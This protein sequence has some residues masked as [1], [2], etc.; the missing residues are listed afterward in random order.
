MNI[1][2]ELMKRNGN[3]MSDITVL[4]YLVLSKTKLNYL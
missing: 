4:S 1:F 3:K 2:A